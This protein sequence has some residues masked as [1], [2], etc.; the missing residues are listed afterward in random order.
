[1]YNL[2]DTIVAIATGPKGA[3]GII[4]VSGKDAFLISSK[5]LKPDTAFTNPKP[6]LSY[7]LKAVDENANLI[8]RVM[9]ITYLKP[10]S[11]TGEDMV[12]VFCH[13]SIYIVKKLLDLFIANGA[14]QAYEGEFSFRAF[15]NGKL[16]LS[17]A[18]GINELIKSET[19]KQ[20]RIAINYV[21]GNFSKKINSIREKIIDF[22][23]Q[24]EVRIDDT[25]Q[26]MDEINISE[27]KDEMASL[28][29]LIERMCDTYKKAEFIKN[30]IKIAIVGSPNSGKSSLLNK[31]IGYERAITSEIPGTTRDSIEVISEIGGIKL[32]F[33]DT[34]G[35][36]LDTSDPIEKQGIENTKKIIKTSDII[37]YLEDISRPE[38]DDDR[39]AIKIINE[40]AN[41]NTKIIKVYSKSDL[42]QLKSKSDYIKISSKT[43]RGIESLLSLISRTQQDIVDTNYDEIVISKRHYQSLMEVK[44]ELN[45]L[46]KI[47]DSKNY[48]IMAEHLRGALNHLEDITGKTT[49][50]DILENIFKNFCVGK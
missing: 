1:M 27:Y 31:I 26:E 17:Q 9:V 34:A 43:G 29:K 19:E 7:L 50:E 22:L 23:S 4:R 24:I 45:S 11:Y 42:K 48:E 49:P 39:Y 12:E 8:D 21:N 15:I 30:G 47:I 3:I 2:S 35:I 6:N 16:D 18:E 44:K 41:P 28:I 10:K 20:H 25:Y 14:R 38:T 13:N 40:N 37:I 32:T 36:R 46:Y 5:I 33:I